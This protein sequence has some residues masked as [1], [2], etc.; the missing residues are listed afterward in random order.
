MKAIKLGCKTGGF[1]FGAT[2]EVGDGEK[3]ISLDV[4]KGLVKDGLA[5]EVEAT[6]VTSGNQDLLDEIEL[7]QD[8]IQILESQLKEAI[9]LPKGQKPSGYKKA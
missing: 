7:L 4:A 3:Q 2:V 8:E 1:K 5:T 6:I 9:D